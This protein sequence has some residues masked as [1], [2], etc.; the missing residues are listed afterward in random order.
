MPLRVFRVFYVYFKKV[1]I[2]PL[3]LIGLLAIPLTTT[4]QLQTP[5]RSNL[6]PEPILERLKPHKIIPGE[7]IESIA[8]E[9][10]LLP[11]TLIRLNQAIAKSKN[12]IGK[13]ILIPP[14]NGIRLEVVPGAT[15]KDLEQAYGVRADVL[16]EI[17]GCQQIPKVVFLPGV[18]WQSTRDVT[19]Q[20]YLGLSHYPLPQPAPIAMNY[21]WQENYTRQ[22][23]MFHPGVDLLA[24]N[25]T[26]VLAAD[27]GIVVF[28]GQQHNYGNLIVINHPGGW[29]TRYGHL[30]NIKVKIAQQ[31]KPGEAIATVGYSGIPDLQESH[32]HFEVRR[33]THLGWLARDPE[34]HFKK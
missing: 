6:C 17:N 1:I 29:Q 9:H 8:K 28:V 2:S 30:S 27:A 32:L 31:V 11:D 33:K 23:R 18:N 12:L 20:N 26:S 10:N 25:G 15:W 22:Q 16:F 4:A 14:F 21:G 7:T 5:A 3:S 24:D 34:L 19:E 13:E